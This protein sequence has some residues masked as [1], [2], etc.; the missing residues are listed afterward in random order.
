MEYEKHRNIIT[1]LVPGNILSDEHCSVKYQE[2]PVILE[3]LDAFFYNNG[4]EKI[5]CVAISIQNSVLLAVVILYLLSENKNFFLLPANSASSDKAPFFCDRILTGASNGNDRST[6]LSLLVL[7]KNEGFVKKKHQPDPLSGYIFLASSGTS[8]PSKYIC[9]NAGNLIENA[10]KCVTRFTIVN[11]TK[12]LITVPVSHMYG[13]GVGL[14]PSLV[15]GAGFRLIERNNIIKLF[16]NV[17]EFKPGITL[18]TPALARMV[19][20]SNKKIPHCRTYIS[21]GEKMDPRTHKEFELNNGLL[22][23]LYGCT[24]LGAIATSTTDA[25]SRFMGTVRPL[26]NVNVMISNEEPGEIL[27]QHDAGFTGYLDDEG[28]IRPPAMT[29]PTYYRT[30][31]AGTSAG[32]GDFIV[33]GRIDNCVNRS[34]FLISLD[35]IESTLKSLFSSFRQVVVFESDVANTILPRLIAVCEIDET[36]DHDDSR[37]KIKCKESMSRYSIPDE[38]IFLLDIP[39]LNNGKADRLYLKRSYGSLK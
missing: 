32:N 39:K 22:V 27:V 8:G 11:S 10:K 37:V 3:E 31:D 14:L 15:A 6:L 34:G 35:E 18:I 28:I 9:Y 20:L 29:V 30:K 26:E 33:S 17:T 38:F 4:G 16:T 1:G 2:L 7:T 23:N 25:E 13:L 19:L 5:T 21:A 24:E 36:N 12:V